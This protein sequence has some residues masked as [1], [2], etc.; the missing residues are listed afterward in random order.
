M[1]GSISPSHHAA[2]L[3]MNAEFVHW[4]APL[5]QQGLEDMLHN[6]AYA[7]QI[8]NGSGVLFGYA[9]DLD[10]PDHDN[11]NW[12]RKRCKNFFYID[13]IIIRNGAQGRGYGQ[14]L[15]DDVERFARDGGFECLTCEVNTRPDNPGSHRFHLAR[16]FE[17][18]GEQ[19]YSPKPDG[20][21]KAVKYYAK[22]L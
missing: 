19:L 15:Y 4:L 3:E 17:V 14:K 9:H 11:L 6:A 22:V 18:I 16:G 12:L 10:D 7:R 20:V 5:N 21:S 1:I 2:I 13:R 8:D